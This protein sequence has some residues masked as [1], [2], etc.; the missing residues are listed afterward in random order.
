MYHIININ[1]ITE[2]AE[3]GSWGDAELKI[4]W[5][6]I[7]SM[8]FLGFTNEKIVADEQIIFR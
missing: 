3:D 8:Y 5:L 7:K 6:F 2:A 1:K 4:F